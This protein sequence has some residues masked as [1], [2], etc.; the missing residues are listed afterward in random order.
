MVIDT[1]AIFAS[2]TGEPDSGIYCSAII[3]AP[4]R[5]IS[6]ATPLET[7]SVLFARSG[8]DSVSVLHELIEHA[9]IAVYR[10]TRNRPRPLSIHSRAMAKDRP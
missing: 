4:L 10:L 2:I 1:S 5:M 7:E 6:A 8:S 9:G 3:S